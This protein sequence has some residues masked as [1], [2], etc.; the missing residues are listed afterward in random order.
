MDDPFQP[1][2][3][4]LIPKRTPRGFSLVELMIVV[5]LIAILAA[6]A[7][8]TIIQSMERNRLNQ[9]NRDIVTG[10]NEAR[11]FAMRTGNAVLVDVDAGDDEIRFLEADSTVTAGEIANACTRADPAT[12][13]ED[14]NTLLTISPDDQGLEVVF[15]TPD[16]SDNP[17]CIGPNGRVLGTNG[18]VLT[19]DTGACSGEMNYLLPIIDPDP[20][21]QLSD[22]RDCTDDAELSAQREI[23]NFSMIHVSPVGQVRVIR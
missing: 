10:F 9:L 11:T 8:P 4:A 21:H 6:I 19:A 1:T 20:V 15:E 2:L 3:S 13:P 16:P 7:A 18:E 5:A 22:L 12:T 23:D 14:D 17:I